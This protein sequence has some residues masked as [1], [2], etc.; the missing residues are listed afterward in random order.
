MKRITSAELVRSFGH[1]TDAAMTEPTVI[2]RNGRDR[3]V[4]LSVDTYRKLLALAV[5]DEI[6]TGEAVRERLRGQLQAVL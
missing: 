6:A 1:H 4:I 3:L 2:T 5:K